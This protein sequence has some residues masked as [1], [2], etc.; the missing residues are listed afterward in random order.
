MS[1]NQ[2][3]SFNPT[4]ALSSI[5][6]DPL[7][8]LSSNCIR[9]FFGPTVQLVADC[10][11]AQGGASTL[12]QIINTIKTKLEERGRTKE[13]VEMIK[14]TRLR[15]IS[16]FGR[17]SA[18]SIGAALLV[19][20][21]HSIV[22][23]TKTLTVIREKK[24]MIYRYKFDPDR[25]RLLPRYPRYVEYTK[26]SMG[27][28]GA[29]LIEELLLQGRMRTVDAVE[30]T[31]EQL[32]QLK[33]PP[34]SD[35]YTYREA[36][37]GC[38]GRLVQGGYIEEVTEVKDDG[39]DAGETEFHGLDTLLGNEESKEKVDSND[40]PATVSLLQSGQYKSLQP[41]TVWKVNI[42]MFHDSLRAVSL[43]TLVY[44]IYGQKVQFAG[45]MVAAALKLAAYKEH[46]EGDKNFES[47][48]L[49]STENIQRYLSKPVFQDLEK[50]P[51]GVNLNMYKTLLEL[52]K[53]H[54]PQVVQQVEVAD[55]HPENAKFQITTSRLVQF[56]QDRIAKQ[57]ILDSHG[58]IAARVYAILRAKGSLESDT[59][60]EIAM[61]PA[62]ETRE[63][64]H[65]LYREKY[66]ALF[67]LNQGKQHNP[68]SMFYIWSVSHARTLQHTTDSVCTA[69]YN[70]RLR[71]QHE[72][73]VGKEWIERQEHGA[74]EENESEIDKLKFTQFCKGMERLD[75]AALQLD[76]TLMVLKDY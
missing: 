21:Q 29:A 48:K 51:G 63:V 3:A 23:Y 12:A 41:S 71:R 52:C 49:F 61:V 16:S 67:N 55:G 45:S 2:F 5:A 36:V 58:E 14:V 57:I 39:G 28:I 43:G 31:V 76:E 69:L 59:I 19:L 70:M 72:V 47:Q 35:R 40:N 4:T 17:P 54:H 46:A 73:E 37:L 44:E 24:K 13:R 6:H 1:N 42:R 38:F 30:Q 74:E 9:D 10:L 33:S 22:T 34:A 53:C 18:N 75:R 32:K 56:L 68:T 8:T 27:E 64:L 60:A 66:I 11:Q 26:K 62:K 20:I 50:K 15:T 7:V 65:R 25:A